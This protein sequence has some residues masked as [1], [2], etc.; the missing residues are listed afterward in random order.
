M[1]KEC[2][3][4]TV[5]AK[6]QIFKEVQTTTAQVII[7][8]GQ[9]LLIIYFSVHTVTKAKTLVALEQ[10]QQHYNLSYFRF[11]TENK[12]SIFF[13]SRLIFRFPINNFNIFF[14]QE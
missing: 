2:Y 1:P 8:N 10:Q 9:L 6:N 14:S 5:I 11:C 4:R 13:V 7:V 12:I 3:V